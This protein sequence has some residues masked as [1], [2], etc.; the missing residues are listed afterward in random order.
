M[1]GGGLDDDFT[2]QVSTTS[3]AGD[4]GEELEGAFSGSEVGRIEGEVSIK[5]ADEGDVWK[6]ESFGDHLG[7]EEDVDLLGA[8]VTEGVAE[9]VF[10][11]GGIGIETGDF[12]AFEDFIENDFRFLGSVSLEADGGVFTLRTEPWDDGLVAADMA[13]EALLRAV[14]GEGDGAVITLDGVSAG[15]ALERS[16]ETSAIQKDDDL[17]VFLEAFLDGGAELFGDDGI[18]AFLLTRLDA[19]VDDAGER[20][21]CSIGSLVEVDDLVFVELRVVEGLERWGG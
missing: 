15:W 14:V 6:V 20:E 2:C 7:A 16:G 4:L 21:G 11:A 8:E 3:A 5:D 13:D 1:R 10:P 18:A 17:L 19:H 9:G 12:C